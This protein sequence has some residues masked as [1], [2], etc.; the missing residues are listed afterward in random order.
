[1]NL[2]ATFVKWSFRSGHALLPPLSSRRNG[3][4]KIACREVWSGTPELLWAYQQEIST[5]CQP[6]FDNIPPD[7]RPKIDAEVSALL[8]RFQSG[9]VLRCPST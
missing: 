8:S 3:T 5:L 6:L 9:S 1:V 7:S 4:I 2:A